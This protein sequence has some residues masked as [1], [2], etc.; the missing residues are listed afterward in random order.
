MKGFIAISFY[1]DMAQVLFLVLKA[2]L[3]YIDVII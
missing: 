2:A 3:Q 1:D